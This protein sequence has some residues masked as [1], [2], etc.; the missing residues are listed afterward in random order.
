MGSTAETA[1]GAWDRTWRNALDSAVSNGAKPDAEQTRRI[2]I[3]EMA[4]KIIDTHLELLQKKDLR[5]LS[6]VLGKRRRR[7]SGRW[8]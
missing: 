5:E 7:R 8:T 3:F 4:T 6:K 2:E 1:R